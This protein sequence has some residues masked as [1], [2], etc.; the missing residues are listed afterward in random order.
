MRSF[1][2]L[3]IFLYVAERWTCTFVQ[4]S[5]VSLTTCSFIAWLSICHHCV[6]TNCLHGP[7]GGFSTEWIGPNTEPCAAPLLFCSFL[8]AASADWGFLT[9]V[10]PY[11]VPPVLCSH[12]VVAST[13]AHRYLNRTS[14]EKMQLLSLTTVINMWGYFWE[15]TCN[16][17]NFASSRSMASSPAPKGSLLTSGGCVIQLEEI[18]SG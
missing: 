3:R 8:M 12:C 14:Q 13:I 11:R 17:C 6:S 10:R 1:Y 2:T 16:C 4:K 5:Q 7:T 9:I 18:L 15:Y